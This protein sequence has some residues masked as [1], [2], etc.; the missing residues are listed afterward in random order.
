MHISLYNNNIS[1]NAEK[2]KLKS[3]HFE[4]RFSVFLESIAQ[5]PFVLDTK[6]KF[7]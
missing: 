1:A 3:G 2:M 4:L 6:L 7:A 5:V